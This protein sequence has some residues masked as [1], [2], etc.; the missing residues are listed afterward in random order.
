MKA[1]KSSCIK[2]AELT[3]LN[4]LNDEKLKSSPFVCELTKEIQKQIST[5]KMNERNELNINC[6]LLTNDEHL[7]IINDYVKCGKFH[8]HLIVDTYDGDYVKSV[9]KLLKLLL[10]NIASP[11][12]DQN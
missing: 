6:K 7:S 10:A 4:P 12:S 8:K 11:I 2:A 9:P 5:K 3:G 1:N